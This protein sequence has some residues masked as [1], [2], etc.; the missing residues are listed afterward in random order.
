[1]LKE[2]NSSWEKDA[3]EK[4]RTKG[5]KTVTMMFVDVGLGERKGKFEIR[6]EVVEGKKGSIDVLNRENKE[7]I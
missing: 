6:E 2:R 5:R 7:A 1:M 4:E 3:G